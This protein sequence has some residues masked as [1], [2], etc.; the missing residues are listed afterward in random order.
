[1]AEFKTLEDLAARA[2]REE[3]PRVD[4]SS[5]VALRLGREAPAPAWPLVFFASSAAAAA[6]AVLIVSFPLID[7]L[8]D[9][10]SAFVLMATNVLP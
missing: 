1:M 2:R 3:P 10:L 8:T 9:P 5:R 6:A 7:M 4:V